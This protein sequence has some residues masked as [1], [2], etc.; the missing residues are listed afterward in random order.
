M[1]QII[2]NETLLTASTLIIPVTQGDT[3]TMKLTAIANLYGISNALLNDFKADHKETFTAYP[4]HDTTVQKIILLGLGKQPAFAEVLLAFRSLSYKQKEKLSSRVA[5]DLSEHPNFA[6]AAVNGLL[7]GT[8]DLALY[9]TD[10]KTIHPLSLPDATTQ[11]MVSD[12]ADVEQAAIRGKHIAE[13]QMRIYDLVNAP[14]NKV[15][16]ETLATWAADSGDKFGY[17]VK[18]HTKAEIE[19]LGLDALLAV[20]RGSEYPP[21]FIVM[22]YQPING[23]YTQTIGLVGKGITFDTGGISIK[24]SSNMHFMKCDMGGAAAVLGAIELA[25]KLQLPVR[26]VGIVPSTDNLVGTKAYKPGDVIGS[27]LGKSIEVIDTDAEGRVILADGLSFLQKNFNPDTIIDLAT[28]TGS[29]IQT[30]G[31]HAGGLFSNN[32]TLAQA[33]VQVGDNVG[34]RLWRLPLWDVYNE[35]VKSE[36]ADVKNYSGKP[37]AGAISAA[38]F[39]EIF[40]DKHEKWAHLDIAG[41][42]FTASEF[43]STRSATAFG[44]RLLVDFLEKQ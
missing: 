39:L 15:I 23:K 9:K 44:V 35:D 16:A 42:A 30:L 28:L 12:N 26:V 2:Q 40:V 33:L 34:E 31:Y 22:D 4:S 1:I 14:G 8:Y 11:L 13:T 10:E 7:L 36:V 17:K 27:Y 3:A 43:T 21:A 37:V 6:E 24:P 20:N 5:V 18:N 32:E 19:T 29:C 41:V 25:A 38:K